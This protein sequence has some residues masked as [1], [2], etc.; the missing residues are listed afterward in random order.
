MPIE[1]D[2]TQSRPRG[3]CVEFL[4]AAPIIAILTALLWQ[5]VDLLRAESALYRAAQIA[6]HE[7]VLPK[8]TIHSVNNAAARGLIGTR[9]L[10]V[11]D[12]P[13]ITVN[14]LPLVRDSLYLLQSG[15]RVEVT[16]GVYAT[17][18]APNLFGPIGLSHDGQKLGATASFIKP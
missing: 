9:L 17:D 1:P 6:A 18:V 12:K 16:L 15:D 7:A 3:T 14:D 11:A 5:F 13:T 10:E 2:V 4:V 8:A